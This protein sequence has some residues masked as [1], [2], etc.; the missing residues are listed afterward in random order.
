MTDSSL[1]KLSKTDIRNAAMQFDP[2]L[3]MAR[4]DIRF[5]V[6]YYYAI[7]EDRKR[8]YSQLREAT[9]RKE[10]NCLLA[11]LALQHEQSED[12]VRQ[13][14]D[15]YS[16]NS[17][18]GRWMRQIYG[19]GPVIAAGILAHVDIEK[20][21][22]AGHIESFAGYNPNMVWEKG[23]KRPYNASLKTL[24]Y[25]A[26]M[27]FVKFS[28]RDE[29]VYGKWYLAK[30]DEYQKNNEEG[31]YKEQ[32]LSDMKHKYKDKST[33]AYKTCM[34]GKLPEAQIIARA[35]RWTIKLFISHLH[36]FWYNNHFGEKPAMPYAISILGH[37]HHIKFGDYPA[38]YG[39]N[40]AA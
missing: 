36:E 18:V 33:V 37:A 39:L 5:L 17:E 11:Y 35:R 19:I 27:S 9:K 38:A 21:P 14:L 34:T 30:K 32:A 22:T 26:G 31:K 29:C 3:P 6:R 28:G 40:K 20:A 15:E 16:N 2:S 24:F 25:H 4:A 7:Q 1:V 12:Y 10:S 13:T 8:S 23:E